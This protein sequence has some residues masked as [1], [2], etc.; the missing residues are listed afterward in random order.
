[1]SKPTLAVIA[2]INHTERK[3]PLTRAANSLRPQV[4]EL[5]IVGNGYETLPDGFDGLASPENLGSSAKLYWAAEWDGYYF[6]CDDDLEYPPDY[7]AR[8]VAEL[9]RWDGEVIV[10]AGG[11][12]MKPDAKRWRDW[13]GNGAYVTA[14]PES[15]W[16]NYC[17]G[18]AFAFDASKI[19]PPYPIPDVNEEEA[20]LSVWAQREG[21]PIRLIARPH[22]WP[23]RIPMP[24]RAW[25]SFAVAAREGFATRGRIISQVE[26]WVVHEP[27]GTTAMQDQGPSSESLD[28]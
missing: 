9:E 27:S 1:V 28:G 13:I 17:G 19:Q 14:V 21:I 12:T 7:V 26:K 10:T 22:D 20:H 16:I 2:T 24:A 3:H 6:C 18:F 15:K 8:M 4:D 5:R 25:T 23:K 11:R